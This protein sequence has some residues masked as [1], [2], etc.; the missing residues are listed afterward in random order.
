MSKET[1]VI[2]EQN[3]NTATSSCCDTTCCT[4]ETKSEAITSN[5]KYE[6]NAETGAEEIKEMVKAKYTE[7]IEQ[8][9][10]C[11][12]DDCCMPDGSSTFSEDYSQLDGYE[13]EADYSLGC[14]IPTEHAKI[15]AGSTVLDL[16]SGAGNDVFVARR[17]VGEEGKVIGVDMTEAMIAQANKNKAKLGY[18]NV[19]F[20]LG[21]IENLPLAAN[22]IDTVISNCVMNLVPNKKQAYSEVYRVLK[23]N[24]HF[25]ISDVVVTS[26]LPQKLQKAA[27]LYA[28]CVTGASLKSD[29]LQI[30]KQNG[31][32]N[33]NI[34]VEREIKLPDNALLKYISQ[35]ELADLRAKKGGIYSITVYG[36]K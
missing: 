21:E 34:V 33:V 18:K 1:N 6:I 28:G 4:E 24:G 22:S 3:I 9:I 31:F 27:E 36:E 16:G 30:I 20:V 32:K 23:T 14:G 11:C 35:K 8:N 15:K 10:S 26:A 29:Y 5:N 17:L 2:K 7:V 25:S 19:E 13:A 12:G